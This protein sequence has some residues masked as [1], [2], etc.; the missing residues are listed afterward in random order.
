MQRFQIISIFVLKIE[1]I[2]FNPLSCTLIFR[3]VVCSILFSF[4]KKQLR[5]E[6]TY[7]KLDCFAPLRFNCEKCPQNWNL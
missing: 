2:I 7:I 1:K 6:L 3:F 5:C 4:A